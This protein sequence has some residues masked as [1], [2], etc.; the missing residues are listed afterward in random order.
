M[1]QAL[2]EVSKSSA[3]R[4]E[5]LCVM[6]W[7]LPGAP[8]SLALREGTGYGYWYRRYY[9]VPGQEIEALVCKAGQDDMLEET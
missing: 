6:K 3:G 8:G 9:L 7:L 2:S 1:N 5:D 4:C